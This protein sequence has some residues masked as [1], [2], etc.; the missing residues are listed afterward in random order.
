M[1]LGRVIDE[2]LLVRLAE[3]DLDLLRALGIGVGFMTAHEVVERPDPGAVRAVHHHPLD[4]FLCVARVELVEALPVRQGRI[5]RRRHRQA[6]QRQRLTMPEQVREFEKAQHVIEIIAADIQACT[7]QHVES[8]IVG[9]YAHDRKIRR[10]AA[11]I[12]HEDQLFPAGRESHRPRC[13]HRLFEE[14]DM[15]NAR[16][17]KAGF[18]DGLRAFVEFRV[19]VIERDR[20]ALD[21]GL[22]AL[23][24]LFFRIGNHPAQEMHDHV[25]ERQAPP[26][27][28]GGLVNQRRTEDRLDRTHQAALFTRLI[29]AYR[30]RTDGVLAGIQAVEH[31]CRN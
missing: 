26:A 27:E 17:V 2:C 18:Q 1:R 31:G 12:D 29:G 23:P 11:D 3:A 22:D 30:L 13:R 6:V 10:A 5:G 16:R 8:G 9:R 15:G 4:L 14:F 19:P 21:D 28:F 24:G 25:T 7:A 20:T